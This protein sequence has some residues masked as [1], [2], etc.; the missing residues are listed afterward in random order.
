[1]NNEK[2]ASLVN[3]LR[4]S[5]FTADHAYLINAPKRDTES[6]ARNRKHLKANTTAYWDIGTDNAISIGDLVVLALPKS[7]AAVYPKLIYAGWLKALDPPRG[8]GCKFLLS[9]LRLIDEID[10]GFKE[11]ILP[12]GGYPQRNNTARLELSRRSL[13]SDPNLG[14]TA[15]ELAALD[16]IA[17]D[18]NLNG[19]E[20]KAQTLAR[21]GQ[22][23]FRAKGLRLWKSACSVTG[24]PVKQVLIASHIKPWSNPSSSPK[25]R[26]SPDNCLI[27]VATLDRLF[28]V[29]L[30]SFKMSGEID[31]STLV[32]AENRRVLERLLLGLT[33]LRTSVLPSG[34]LNIAQKAY[35]AFHRRM[36]GFAP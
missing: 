17:S 22:G 23:V 7:Q 2:Q 21:I 4:K 27:L 24:I 10:S 33:G 30:I 14:L 5:G 29:G 12:Y 15:D 35:L 36:H 18:K 20:R 26:V 32:T 1:M 13:P 25:D 28:D 11:Y 16:S 6:F 34:R 19:T 9:G 3:A 8:S 31:I